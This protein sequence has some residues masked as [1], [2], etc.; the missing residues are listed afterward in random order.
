MPDPQKK[1]LI[2][3]DEKP[4]ARALELKLGHSGFMA[5]SV[6]DGEQALAKLQ[7]EQFDLMLLDLMMPKLDGFTVL[8]ELKKRGITVPVIVV[9][10]LNQPEDIRKAM[11]LGAK[12]FF[13]KSDTPL[14]GV[15]D[16]VKRTLGL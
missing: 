7:K 13:I 1:I 10:N 8:E 16:H 15:V 14:S 6:F 2:V 12:D 5:E 4:I 3:E 11:D 9:S